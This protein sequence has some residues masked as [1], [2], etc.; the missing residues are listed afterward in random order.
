MRSLGSNDTD[1]SLRG[2]LDP[3]RKAKGKQ[4]LGPAHLPANVESRKSWGAKGKTQGQTR[5]WAHRPGR[6]TLAALYC[7]AWEK[8]R[9]SLPAVS[10]RAHHSVFAWAQHGGNEV[11]AHDTCTGTLVRK[12]AWLWRHLNASYDVAFPAFS[13]AFSDGLFCVCNSCAQDCTWGQRGR[14]GEGLSGC[15]LFN[16]I[17]DV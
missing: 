3:P 13:G 12:T 5:T 7:R 17:A 6:R 14:V 1:A 16:H 11:R 15:C 4:A 10:L 2:Q 9:T 8:S